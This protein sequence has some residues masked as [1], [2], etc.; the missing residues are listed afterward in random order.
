MEVSIQILGSLGVLVAIIG[1]VLSII[2]NHRDGAIWVFCVAALLAIVA[3]F[4]WLQDRAWKAD[5]EE[6]DRITNALIPKGSTVPPTKEAQGLIDWAKLQ[7]FSEFKLLLEK[8]K[9]EARIPIEE[10]R[11]IKEDAVARDRA[12]NKLPGFIFNASVRIEY[13]KMDR[14]QYLFDFGTENAERFSVYISKDGIFTMCLYDASGEPHPVQVPIGNG[15]VPAS[16][17]IDL[18]FEIGIADTFTILRMLVDGDVKS[19]TRLPFVVDI[20][21]LDIPN[22]IVGGDLQKMNPSYFH[23]Y[24]LNKLAYILPIEE[25]RQF[26]ALLNTTLLQNLNEDEGIKFD[27]IKFMKFNELGN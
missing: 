10:L 20:G 15:G 27:G 23:A 4:C 13:V 1:G 18:G 8:A 5:K 16:K 11:R 25:R 22:G 19:S 26:L 24:F 2:P 12:A 6:S 14:R 7:A 3:F 9:E 21:R 17:K